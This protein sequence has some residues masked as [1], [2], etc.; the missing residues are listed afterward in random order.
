MADYSTYGF[1][2]KLAKPF[3]VSDLRDAIVAVMNSE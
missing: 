1:S 3:M 2:G